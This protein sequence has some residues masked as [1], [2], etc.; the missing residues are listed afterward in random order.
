MDSEFEKS[1]EYPG[2]ARIEYTYEKEK[3]IGG[4]ILKCQV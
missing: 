3:Q 2:Q 1:V 4:S